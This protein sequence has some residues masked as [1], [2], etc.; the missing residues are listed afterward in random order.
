MKIITQTWY[1]TID[2]GGGQSLND[3]DNSP[4]RI[5][6]KQAVILILLYASLAWRMTADGMQTLDYHDHSLK[7]LPQKQNKLKLCKASGAKLNIKP[8]TEIW[9]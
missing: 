3:R 2:D 7:L 1:R 9:C 8:T 4:K 5:P 6:H